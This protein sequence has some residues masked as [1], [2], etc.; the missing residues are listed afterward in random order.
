MNKNN[1]SH[2]IIS[3]LLISAVM[4]TG[5]GMG[6]YFLSKTTN[7]EQTFR[8][9]TTISG[10]D[11]SGLTRMQ[12][13]DKLNATMD[14]TAQDVTLDIVYKDK[15]WSFNGSNFEVNSNID[16]IVQSVY[17]KKRSGDY[18]QNVTLVKQI[19]DM[20]FDSSVALNYVFCG[21]EEKVNS[22][23]AEIEQSPQD[24]TITFYPNSSTMFNITPHTVGISV[25]KVKLYD[26]ISNALALS[27]NATVQVPVVEILPTVTQDKLNLATVKQGEYK[28]DYSKSSAERKSNIQLAF[29]KINGTMVAAGE[30][31]S[32][33]DIVGERTEANGFKTAKVI[34]L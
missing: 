17:N 5:L 19:Q 13:Q 29:S 2:K 26:D 6:G 18:Y 21:M 25:D 33:N 28:T 30:Q 12:A 9:N 1:L 32:F 20:G 4:I 22:I 14:A 15:V 3:S 31:F 11:V 24:A 8:Q 7:Q 23:V 16:D 27:K 34:I 10:V